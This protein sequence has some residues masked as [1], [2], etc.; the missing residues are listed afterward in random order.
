VRLRS[1]TELAALAALAYVPFLA[2]SPGKVSAD[3][4]QD[5]Y[6]DPGRFLAR[7]ADLWD[8]HVGAG[9]VPH[10]NLGYLFPTGPWFWAADRL[11]MPDWVAQRLWLGTISLVA[12]LGARWLFRALGTGRSG[13]LAGG[14]V[15]MLTPYQLAFTARMSVLLLPWAALPWLVGLTMRATRTRDWQAPALLALALLA[16]GGINASSLLLVIVG[17]AIWVALEI[18]RGA[19]SARR[20]LAATVRIAVLGLGISLWWLAGLR[21]QAAHGLPVLQLT[22]NVRTVAEFATP[23][24][25]LRGIGNWFFYGR[26][27]T[28]YSIDQAADYSSGDLVIALS[29]LVPAAALASAFLLRWAH[30]TYF[31]LL[32][33]VG[34]VIGVGSWPYDD[35][36]PYGSLWKAF[37]SDTSL[38]LALRNS[39]RIVPV[40]VLGLAGLLA[41]AVG[42]LPP[43]RWRR[44]GA[45][46]VAVL[47]LATVL[48]VAQ[49]GYLTEGM[50]RP[51]E[52][53]GY[54]RD[55]AAALD[56]GDHGTRVLEVPGSSFAAYRW[57]TTVDPITPALIDRP[58][59]AREVLPSGTPG[60]ALLLDALDRRMQ[61]GWFEPAALA[62]VARLFGVGTIALRADLDQT[63]RFDTPPPASLWHALTGGDA[64]LGA[65]TRFGPP[66]GD[67][68]AADL[69]SVALFAVDDPQP[70]VR[71]A[72]VSDPV[73]LAGDADGIVDAAAAGL[74]DGS[75]LVFLAAALDAPTLAD[76]LEADARLV[77]TD[78]NRRRIQTWFYS[79][80]DTR[81][82][83][84]QAGETAPDPT[85]YDVRLDPF[86]GSTDDSRTVV[87]QVG[88]R[89]TATNGGG[90][91]HPE[92]RAAH[93]VDGDPTTAWRVAEPDPRGEVLTIQPDEPVTADEV[94][95]VQPAVPPGGR[96]LARV[97]VTIDDAPPIVVELG[98]DSMTP[99]GQAVPFA[100]RSVARLR[101]ELLETGPPA[102]TAGRPTPVGLA[103]VRL[104]DLRVAE[105]VRLPTDLLERVGS[106]LDSHSLDIV[107]T[108]LRLDL[109][110]TDRRDDETRLDRRLELPSPRSFMLSGTARL[111]V[112]SAGAVTSTACRDDLLTIDGVPIPIR[113][114]Q[115]SDTLAVAACAQ[116][117]LQAGSH[118][119]IAAAGSTSGIDLDR[120]VLSSGADGRPAPVAPRGA[121][122]ALAGSTVSVR[123]QGPTDLD[124][125]VQGDGRPFWL[126]LG[127][128][129]SDGWEIAVDGASTGPRQL[130][131]G[132]ANGWLV[133]PDGRGTLSI[134]LRWAP[135]RF[136]WL[137]FA[138][139]A[140][141]L[142]AC[143]LLLWCG[144]RPARGA[145]ALGAAP[146]LVCRRSAAHERPR[147]RVI[148]AG[149]AGVLGL[150][151]A[152]PAVAAGAVLVLLCWT[153]V[154][155]TPVLVAAV[156]PAALL[157]SRAGDRPTL[158]WL[159]VLLLLGEVVAEAA[160]GLVG[161][162]RR[163]RVPTGER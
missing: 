147:T 16:A 14:L 48:P 156:A 21:L 132:Y 124:L 128:S 98:P 25:I 119:I 89:V 118:R 65:P 17:P 88:G 152:P 57:G 131:D 7:A 146:R 58:Y 122:A 74:I 127:Q 116:V 41:A 42:A 154:P 142:V 68:S 26:D 92:D 111:D 134:H 114:Q 19:R 110:G 50:Q 64:D 51:E 67:G 11:G 84:E 53:P 103:E 100:R 34:T 120:L 43:L 135:Q 149:V 79:L 73:V 46:A 27:R 37:T 130:V 140:V 62:P 39:P 23:G 158:A 32:V 159:A 144:R 113:L 109:P 112:T 150:A 40:V 108:R 10:Q 162:A 38:G 78:S 30:R 126:M 106:A 115:A 61:Q 117:D 76:Q 3:S 44:L 56:A 94:R 87:E 97:K 66:G 96:A 54:W 143:L 20:A 153:L 59:L 15:Y 133:T 47:A 8:P 145:V 63:G 107:L 137:G 151:V 77:L 136:V 105:T 60:T 99:D 55:V 9:T 95:L 24:D 36:S 72:P 80:R 81:G 4:K 22:E 52:I 93:A 91:E 5:L 104:G 160:G 101:I 28:G 49:H 102:P 83:T 125:E 141:T 139:S 129:S 29:Y 69:P 123:S 70:V 121:P 45:A 2:S 18:G 82:P 71:V 33:V 13:A 163:L 155:W 31:A 161:G 148:G 35:P 90:P 157:A 138:V 12:V 86:P 75:A 6:L 85:G 1:K